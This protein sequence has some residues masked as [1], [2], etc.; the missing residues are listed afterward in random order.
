M[1]TKFSLENIS[2]IFVYAKSNFSYIFNYSIFEKPKDASKGEDAHS[3]SDKLI[4][5]A[6]GVGGWNLH[7]VDP[8]KYSKSLVKS[9]TEL[10]NKNEKSKFNDIN[11]FA[12]AVNLTKNIKGSSTFCSCRLLSDRLSTLNLGDSRYLLMKN[13]K[14]FYSSKEQQ[15]SFNFPFQVGT[16]GDS[17]LSAQI[18]SHIVNEGDII[19]LGTDGLWDNVHDETIVDMISNSKTVKDIGKYCYQKSKDKM[20]I[21]PFCLHSGLRYFGGKPDD[22]TIIMATIKKI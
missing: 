8:S 13:K 12:K 2:K 7:G 10:F 19:V 15:H 9:F 21:S 14:I 5:V 4:C 1:L 18:N 16:N 11:L 3:A 6:D 20:Y 22:I 17:P